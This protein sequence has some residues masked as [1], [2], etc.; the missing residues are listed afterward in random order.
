MTATE[1]MPA[2]GTIVLVACE[3]MNV[4][5]H[6]VDVKTSWGKR[7]LQVLPVA[8]NG[9]QWVELTRV[10]MGECRG[11]NVANDLR[12]ASVRS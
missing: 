9:T 6:V 7:R 8:G 1:M 2:V 3:Q 10:S 11:A 12:L 4:A 5:C